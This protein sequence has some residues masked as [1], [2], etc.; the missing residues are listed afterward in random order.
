MLWAAGASSVR[1]LSVESL[2]EKMYVAV[3]P[4]S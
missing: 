3:R 4:A 1:I 2:T